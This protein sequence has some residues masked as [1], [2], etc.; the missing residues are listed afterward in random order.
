MDLIELMECP[1]ETEEM[2]FSILRNSLPEKEMTTDPEISLHYLPLKNIYPGLDVAEEIAKLTSDANTS[3]QPDDKKEK[4]KAETE[5]MNLFA[6][7][8]YKEAIGQIQKRR[9]DGSVLTV[10]SIR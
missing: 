4:L 10:I 9:F 6:R 7:E 8:F 5:K 3:D 1:N 2:L